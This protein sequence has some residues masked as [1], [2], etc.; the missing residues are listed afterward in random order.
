MKFLTIIII[1]III[2]ILKF[3]L[4]RQAENFDMYLLVHHTNQHF[5]KNNSCPVHKKVSPFLDI[6]VLTRQS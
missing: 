1:I 2:I 6:N 4:Q 5:I 3:S